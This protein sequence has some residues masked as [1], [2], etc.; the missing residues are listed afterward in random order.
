MRIDVSDNSSSHI[1][2]KCE[3][4]LDYKYFGENQTEH[5][6]KI[7]I[8]QDVLLRMDKFLSSDKNHELGGVLV[9]DVCINK[10]EEQFILIDNVI[11]AQHTTS[12][13]S[14]LTFTHETWDRI[15]EVLENDFPGKKI[16]GWFH[17]H[18]GH[19]VFLSNYDIFI[20]ENF[21]NAEYMVAYVF[22]PT[23]DDRGFFSWKNSKVIKSKGYYVCDVKEDDEFDN[24][25]SIDPVPELI[26]DNLPV[27]SSKVVNQKNFITGG[28]L[29][30]AVLLMLIMVYNYFDL[31]KNAL[32]KEDYTKDLAELKIENKKLAERL[33]EMTL[34]SEFKRRSLVSDPLTNTLSNNI[35]ATG[36]TAEE[37]A[38]TELS[39]EK[40]IE[41]PPV[42]KDSTIKLTSYK[43]KSGDTIE[44]ISNQFYKSRVGIEIILKQNNIKNKADIKIGQILELPDALE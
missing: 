15:N 29:V 26:N 28:L 11:N 4:P 5:E 18:P 34:E 33:N 22:D 23:I 12:S 19:T 27:K 40:Q 2:I 10:T 6:I 7:F 43:V 3:F 21:F 8:R 14:R 32:L 24:F 41:A 1:H 9:G 20:Q 13:L 37:K 39:K 25:V 31:K 16:L 44:K 38:D 30:L 36:N 35:A 17:S 42:A